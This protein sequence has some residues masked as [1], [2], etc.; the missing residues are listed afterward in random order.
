MRL[1]AALVFAFAAP[2]AE[3]AWPDL[4]LGPIQDNS[5]LVEEAYNQEAGVVQ[6]IVNAAYDRDIHGSFLTF[7]QEWPVF[8]ETNQLSFTVP[9]SFAGQPSDSSGV[10]DVFLNYRENHGVGGSTPSLATLFTRG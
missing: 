7:T 3:A 1:A 6:H 5:F 4:A 8:D 9:F 10:G 2:V